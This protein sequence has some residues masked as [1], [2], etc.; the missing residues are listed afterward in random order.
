[1]HYVFVVKG[2]QPHLHMSLRSLPFHRPSVRD[3]PKPPAHAVRRRFE[4]RRQ[5]TQ[6]GEPHPEQGQESGKHPKSDLI[7]R[8]RVTSTPISAEKSAL[9]IDDDCQPGVS[10]L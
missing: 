1:M 8:T 10:H 5:E 2:N 9:G 3:R 7:F 4:Y 6:Q